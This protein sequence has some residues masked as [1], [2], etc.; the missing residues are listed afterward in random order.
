M[1]R[2]ESVISDKE[3]IIEL[4]VEKHDFSRERVEKSIEELS[5]QQA[6]KGLSEFF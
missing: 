1:S 4:L 5:K 6:Q 2:F 3:K